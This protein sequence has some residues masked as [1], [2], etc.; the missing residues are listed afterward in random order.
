MKSKEALKM[1]FKLPILEREKENY[2][3]FR[4]LEWTDASLV[5]K[6]TI[7]GMQFAHG[8]RKIF[9]EHIAAIFLNYPGNRQKRF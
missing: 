1:E 9:R 6:N 4:K 8:V 3:F 2:N 5:N 7:K